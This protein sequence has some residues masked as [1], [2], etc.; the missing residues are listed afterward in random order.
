MNYAIITALI[1]SIA[2]EIGI[3]PEFALSIALEENHAL[4]P[5]AINKNKDGTYDGGIFQLNSSW[6]KG[7]IFDPETNIRAG[8]QHIKTLI[9]DQRLNTYW[10]VAASYNCGIGRFLSDEGP[11]LQ[12]ID[13]AGRVMNRWI[14]FTNGNA[15]VV[16]DGKRF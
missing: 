9:D 12:S 16:L 6:Y 14:E 4:N 5:N 3:P 15:P 13:Y 8:C 2:A 7:D 1:L 11:P 10:G